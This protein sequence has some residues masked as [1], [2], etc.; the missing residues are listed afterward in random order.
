MIAPLLLLLLVGDG[1][2]D[3]CSDVP[4]LP[5]QAIDRAEA[6]IYREVGDDERAAGHVL[7][8]RSAY[9]EALRRDPT[10][11]TARARLAELC[12]TN[13]ESA[14]EPQTAPVRAPDHF[15]AGL[16]LMKRGDRAAAIAAFDAARAL[17][18]DPG[19]ALLE[20]ICEYEEGRDRKA[21]PLLEQARAD[22]KLAGTALL[23]LGLIALHDN[24]ER[25]ASSLLDD[26]AS[27]DP[28]LAAT[29]AGLARIARR[30]GRVVASVL[31]E[32]GYD[33]NA[34]LAPERAIARAGVGDGYAAMVAGV[35]LRPFGIPGP[36]ARLT[37]QYRK[38]FEIVSYDVGD[39]A[40]AIG[41]Q[42]GRGRRYAAAE[43]G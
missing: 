34:S 12:R 35:F 26:A 24:Q 39:A 10:D 29:A 6:L 43:Y 30:D 13:A 40:G 20:G 2:A 27:K 31:A 32:A 21:Q 42:L 7:A 14:A 36:Y 41:F 8:A 23:F 37:G 25:A 4:A 16:A 22:P 19:A 38:Q 33:S 15:E 1:R 11:A 3:S 17:G 18:A 9:R 28:R 5:A